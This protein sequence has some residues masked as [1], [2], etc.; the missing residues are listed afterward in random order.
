MRQKETLRL[1]GGRFNLPPILFG[2][3]HVFI[4]ETP[5]LMRLAE[6]E[7]RQV[8]IK[9]EALVELSR[10]AEGI[11]TRGSASALIFLY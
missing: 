9:F 4:V 2:N 7:S 5:I 11:Y 8:G 3:N 1:A 6:N 10:E